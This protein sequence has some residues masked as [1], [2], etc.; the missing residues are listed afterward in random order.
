MQAE[1]YHTCRALLV[2]RHDDLSIFDRAFD[3]FWRQTHGPLSREPVPD[4]GTGTRG[5]DDSAAAGDGQQRHQQLAA[6]EVVDVDDEARGALRTWSDT[7]TL[8]RAASGTG[9]RPWG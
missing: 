2:H 4:G 7:A 5:G 9:T 3:A 8:A 6:S 1:V